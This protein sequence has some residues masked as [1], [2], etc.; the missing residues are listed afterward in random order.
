[1]KTGTHFAHYESQSYDMTGL[2]TISLNS[3]F[4]FFNLFDT[5]GYEKLI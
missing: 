4:F 2:F 1:M 5:T 3:F